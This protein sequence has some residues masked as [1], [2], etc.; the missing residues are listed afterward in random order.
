MEENDDA[1]ERMRSLNS[2]NQ[3]FYMNVDAF[4]EKMGMKS[5]D[6]VGLYLYGSRLWGTANA[7]SDYDFLVVVKSA[8]K[9]CAT[10]HAGNIDCLAMTQAEFEKRLQAHSFLCVMCVLYLAPEWVWKRFVPKKKFAL[11]LKRFE[12]SVREEVERDWKVAT[13]K[14]DKGMGD[15]ANKVQIHA[16]RMLRILKQI[17]EGNET[18][19]LTCAIDLWRFCK[20]DYTGQASEAHLEAC[21]NEM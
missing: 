7:Q 14:R 12:A 17:Q 21:K 4:A 15:A 11:D 3:K 8:D 1:L 2:S 9:P 20:E 16:I 19:S 18:P 10:R 5:K 6:I 13:K